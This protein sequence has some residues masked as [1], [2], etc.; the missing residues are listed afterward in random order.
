VFR[1]TKEVLSSRQDG[2][3][4]SGRSGILE[5]WL[6]EVEVSFANAM[7]ELYACQSDR[8]VPETFEAEHDVRSGLDVPM[9]LLDQIIQTLRGSDRRTLGQQAVRLPLGGNR[10]FRAISGGHRPQSPVQ[11]GSPV[12]QHFLETR[13]HQA[14]DK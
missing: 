3:P 12:L 11:Q 8:G 14:S 7:H 13:I 6:H 4:H 2:I 10:P 1:I 9:V 5:A